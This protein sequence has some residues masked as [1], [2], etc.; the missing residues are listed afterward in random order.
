VAA[1][2]ETVL[3]VDDDVRFRA[4]VHELLTR[5]G[6]AVEEAGDADEA[7]ARVRRRAPDLV[8]LDVKLPRVSGYELFREL[9]DRLGENLPVVFVS[10]ER[11]DT[12][13]RIAGLLL[14]ADDYLTKPFDPSELVARV[15]RLVHRA[16]PSGGRDATG[17]GSLTRRER[18][19]LALLAAGHSSDQIAD[20]LAI[21]PRTLGTHVQHILGKLDVRNRAQAVAVAHRAGLVDDVTAHLAAA[22]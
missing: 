22:T 19:V 12:Y 15:R 3:V 7:L 4:F 8:V 20:E 1:A 21:S 2:A 17:I 16:G 11:V 9:H 14:G 10:G 13:D 18:E 5:A 6:F